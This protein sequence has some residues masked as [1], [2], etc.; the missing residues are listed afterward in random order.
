MLAKIEVTNFK[1]FNDNFIFDLNDTSSFNFN[2]ECIKNKIVNKAI[3]YGQNGCGK[4]NLGFAIFDLVSHLTDKQTREEYYQNYLNADSSEKIATFKFTFKFDDNIVEYSYTKTEYKMLK[5]E[6]LTINGNIFASIDKV[7]S[8]I[9]ETFAKG[10]ETLNRDMK[11]SNISI[12]SYI[13][14]NTVLE[15]TDTNKIFKKFIDFVNKMLYF[16]TLDNKLHMGLEQSIGSVQ[17]DIIERGNLLDFESFLNS[18]GVKCKL[19]ERKVDNFTLICFEFKNKDINFI[20][21]ASSGTTSLALFYFWYQRLKEENKVSFLFID[22][23]DAY[24]HHTLSRVVIERLR[25]VTNTQVIVT[26]HN[27]SIISNDLLRPDCYFLMYPDKIKSLAKSTQKELR[28]A[29][30]IEKMYRAGSFE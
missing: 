20:D 14:K 12:I 25:E 27:T 6:K 11:D 24:Y 18:V 5:S 29:H 1:S 4:S 17:K 10:A 3:I 15:D 8:N 9:F 23:F 16:R 30:N 22:E 28:E 13:L 19:K 26:T 2:P 21:I 7:K